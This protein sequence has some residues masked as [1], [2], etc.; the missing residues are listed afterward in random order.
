MRLV[1][2]CRGVGTFMIFFV[3]MSFWPITRFWVVFRPNYTRNYTHNYTSD[4]KHWLEEGLQPFIVKIQK[5]YLAVSRN[6]RIFANE[7]Y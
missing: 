5:K 7:N 2:W 3:E 6:Y 1:V 4:V